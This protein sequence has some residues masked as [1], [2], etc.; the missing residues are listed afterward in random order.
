M[1]G[2]TISHYK[3]L[4]KIGEGG[5]GEVYKAQ[6]TKLKR[7]VTLK[8]LPQDITCNED[9]KIRFMQEAQAALAIDHQNNYTIYRIDE[10]EDGQTYLVKA[11][12]DAEILKSKIERGPLKRLAISILLTV[13]INSPL[14]GQL[15]IDKIVRSNWNPTCVAVYETGN[16]FFVF[17]KNDKILYVYDGVTNAE[18]D[19]V[20]I[21]L[22]DINRI[23]I[24]E[25]N[26]K[27][28]A[29]NLSVRERKIAVVDVVND[30]LLHYIPTG[31]FT[32]L[33]KDEELD[34]VYALFVLGF[35]QI[36]TAT[37]SVISIPG[38]SG[39][40]LRQIAVNFDP[41]GQD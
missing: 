2:K 1:I 32:M 8:F 17:D 20:F 24:D 29:A 23:V 13:F 10:T 21:N 37:D 11:Y 33:A 25:S 31:T 7:T 5:M 15:V 39:N 19:T 22:E 40:V 38:I 4:E 30:S 41:G 27:L 14:L 34:K 36:D 18:L 26:G 28:Y 9:A 16:K 3:I 35:I 12:Y 6:D